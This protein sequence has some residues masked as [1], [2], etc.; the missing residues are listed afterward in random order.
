[1][2][3]NNNIAIAGIILNL[4]IIIMIIIMSSDVWIFMDEC[5]SEYESC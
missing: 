5:S 1:M 2:S 4:E 3:T